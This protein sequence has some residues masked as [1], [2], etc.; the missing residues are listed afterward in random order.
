[1][2]PP[3]LFQQP[4][5]GGQPNPTMAT[6][7]PPHLPLPN[8]QVILS[9]ESHAAI[10]AS[11]PPTVQ[12][13]QIPPSMGYQTA[14]TFEDALNPT[15]YIQATWPP[16]AVA[17]TT[18]SNAANPTALPTSILSGAPTSQMLGG[19]PTIL[20]YSMAP[21]DLHPPAVSQQPAVYIPPSSNS[22]NQFLP[23]HPTLHKVPHFIWRRK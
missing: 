19:P 16:P 11:A 15:Q 1:M 20:I 7:P 14:P 8:Q 13:F 17:N 22:S 5:V 2:A 3:T 23:V 9:G 6:A 4:S 10:P 21:G 12:N 18:F